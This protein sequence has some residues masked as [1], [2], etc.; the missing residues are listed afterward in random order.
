MLNKPSF[1]APKSVQA[2][3]PS[4]V[5][6][7]MEKLYHQQIASQHIQFDAAQFSALQHLQTVL[8][9]LLIAHQQQRK[10]VLHKWLAPPPI[11][12]PSLYIFGDVGR[13]KSMLMALFFD[14]CPIQEKRRV[15]FSSFMLE[16]HAFIHAYR[17]TDGSDALS[18]LAQQIS[19][20]V[21][22]LCFDEFH[23]TDIADAMILGRLFSKLFEAN[24]SIIMT[25]NRH[26][27]D[28][29]QGGLQREQFL[30]F[31]K[32]LRNSAEIIELVAKEDYRLINGMPASPSYWHPLGEHADRF[33]RQSYQ[34]LSQGAAIKPLTLTVSGRQ[35][36]LSAAHQDII[37]T[38]FEAL[39]VQPLGAADYLAITQHCR[40]LILSDIPKLTA[41]K[42]N[43]AKRFVTLVDVLYEHHIQLIC[44]AEV[45]AQDLYVEG[46][47]A[48]EF[49]RTVSRLIEMQ[50]QGYLQRNPVKSL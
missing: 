8:E 40:T 10:P 4:H 48:F 11:K 50:S 20:S 29:Y 49:R 2:A 14:A 18:A 1:F 19:A 36:L 9:Q 37:M 5:H 15:H 25:S 38:S 41:E 21:S 24:I 32:V 6:G 16:V 23:V 31:I 12:F 43:E 33:V 35:V 44:S 7:L 17:Q 27:N 45:P 22:L 3:V 26:P 13:G 28:L 39:C 42:R 34:D 47:G 46:D 30:F